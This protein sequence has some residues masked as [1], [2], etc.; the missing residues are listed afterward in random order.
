MPE[1][2]KLADSSQACFRGRKWQKVESDAE[3]GIEAGGVSRARN[4]KEL[5]EDAS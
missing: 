2:K 5:M 3:K 4:V 1:P